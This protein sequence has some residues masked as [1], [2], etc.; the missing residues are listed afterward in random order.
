[1][2]DTFRSVL[3]YSGGF[4]MGSLWQSL[5]VE[6]S[7]SGKTFQEQIELFLMLLGSLMHEGEIRFASGGKYLGGSAEEQLQTLRQSL[8]GTKA[9]LEADM[10]LWFLVSA[11]AGIVWI[12]SDGQEIWT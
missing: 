5:D 3:K 11:P 4:S 9:E 8:P 7:G 6:L 2:N 10:G 1:M 12:T